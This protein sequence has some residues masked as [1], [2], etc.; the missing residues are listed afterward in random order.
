MKYYHVTSF[1]NAERILKEGLKAN[2]EGMIFLFLN[3][4]L[5]STVPVV[6]DGRVVNVEEHY[7]LVADHIATRQTFTFPE[8][9]ILEVDSKGFNKELK[10]D[11][12]GEGPSEA[13][14]QWYLEQETIEPQYIQWFGMYKTRS[15]I[16]RK[17]RN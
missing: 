2:E 14:M 12:V 4:A 17:F 11:V 8:Y 5:K 16:Y 9:V 6:K 1:E 15:S 13:H 3:K 7:Y 10:E